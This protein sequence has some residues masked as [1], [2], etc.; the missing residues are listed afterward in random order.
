MDGDD[1]RRAI[2]YLDETAAVAKQAKLASHALLEITSGLHV[3]DVGCGNG[4][5]VRAIC[6]L[7]GS[8]G[9]VVGIDSSAA[10]IAE[11]IGRGVPPNAHFLRGSA[12]ALPFEDGAFD[13]FRAERVIQHLAQPERAFSEARRVLRPGGRLLVADQDWGTLAVD[14]TSSR[15]RMALRAS[16]CASI[17][18]PHAG[19]EHA[20]Q[21]VRAGFRD[22][23]VHPVVA[24]LSYEQAYRFVLATALDVALR[25]GRLDADE[26]ELCNVELRDAAARGEFLYTVTMYVALALA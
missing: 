7:V 25:S 14:G 5:D 11:C 22:V 15:F 23:V 16:F 10:L 1:A 18:N 3:L 17:T 8:S 9:S 12:E 21:L 13:R 4:D 26:A 6:E 24:R 19:L 20:R 2:A